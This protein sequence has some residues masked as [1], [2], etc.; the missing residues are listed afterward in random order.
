MFL[1]HVRAELF[2]QHC[3]LLALVCTNDSIFSVSTHIAESILICSFLLNSIV[4]F[5]WSCLH[6]SFSFDQEVSVDV[7]HGSKLPWL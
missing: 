6:T 2:P 5:L 4:V 7:I 3:H 1:L